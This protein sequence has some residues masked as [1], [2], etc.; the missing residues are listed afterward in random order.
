SATCVSEIMSRRRLEKTEFFN[1]FLARD[2]LHYGI[3]FYA[4]CGGRNIGDLRIWRSRQKED[5]SRREA[6]MLDT[7]GEAFSRSLL[8]C[9]LN[10]ASPQQN[11][12]ID[13]LTYVAR[14]SDRVGLTRRQREIAA[15]ILFGSSDRVI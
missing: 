8:Q 5:F 2:G 11:V 10:E 3:N 6:V 12:D 15:A 7:I 13:I 4:Y 14:A 1:D 9:R